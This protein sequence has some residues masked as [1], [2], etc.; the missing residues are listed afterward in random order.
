MGGRH[1]IGF[2]VSYHRFALSVVL[3]GLLPGWQPAFGQS[4]VCAQL[5]AQLDAV[6]RA[7]GANP[8]RLAQYQNAI[9]R[10]RVEMNRTIEYSASIGCDFEPANAQCQSLQTNIERMQANLD[11]LEEDARRIASNAGQSSDGERARIIAALQGQN[12]AGFAAPAARQNTAPSIFDG[13]FGGEVVDPVDP[14]L[15]APDGQQGLS[16]DG[17]PLEGSAE[18][19]VRTLC[20]RKCDGYYFPVSFASVPATFPAQEQACRAMCPA[21]EVELFAYA[22]MTETPEQAVSTS[23]GMMLRDMPNAFKFR[24]SYDPACSCKRPG[25]SWAEALAPAEAQLTGKE[26]DIVVTEERSRQMATPK[27]GVR[28]SATAESAPAVDPA[29]SPTDLLQKPVD[30]QAAAGAPSTPAADAPIEPAP[31]PADEAASTEP[32]P[33]PV[34][35]PRNISPRPTTVATPAKPKAPV[36]EDPLALDG[37][38]TVAPGAD[39]NAPISLDGA[40]LFGQ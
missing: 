1:R 32:V 11:K 14:S 29:D 22:P 40:S 15:A 10:Q 13:L 9:D 8:A 23:T 30:V 20:V 6:E 36:I 35:R 16:P 34:P 31:A 3:L 27:G 24:T 2:V 25:E 39:P 4:A 5:V 18:N 21:A 12:C 33:L 19:P 38:T 26:G 37:P 28:A 17:M 7:G